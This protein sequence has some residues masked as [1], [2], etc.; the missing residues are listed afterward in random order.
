MHTRKFSSS[1][2]KI[3]MF[4]TFNIDS[5]YLSSHYLIQ[6]WN[7]NFTLYFHCHKISANFLLHH[8][9]HCLLN[10]T[11]FCSVLILW[12]VFMCISFVISVSPAVC[13]HGTTQLPLDDCHEIL[14][15]NIVQK[16]IQKFPVSLKSDKN[17]RYFTWRPLYIYDHFAQFLEWKIFQ[18]TVIQK[19]QTHIL[20]GLFFFFNRCRSWDNV[21]KYCRAGQATDDNMAHAICMLDT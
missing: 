20:C 4:S 21:E 8:G 12:S 16:Y 18:T 19:I 3:W 6:F 15:L 9:Q 10:N 11:S 14:H 13:P 1:K 2:L 7:W 5:N 17:N